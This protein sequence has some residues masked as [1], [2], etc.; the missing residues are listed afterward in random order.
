MVALTSIPQYWGL[1]LDVIEKMSDRGFARELAK[2]SRHE[3][4]WFSTI[5]PIDRTNPFNP[6]EFIGPGWSFWRGPADGNGLEGE[7]EQ[8]SRSLALTEVDLSKVLLEVHL[9]PSETHTTG[10]ERLGRLTVANR[11]RL[12]LGVFK[13]LWDNKALISASWK[14][15]TNGN[16]TYIFFDGQVLRSPSGKRYTLCLCWLGGK[17]RR[18]CRWL[19]YD[20]GAG[21]P[22]AVLAS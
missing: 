11:I 10:E 13:T 9:N 7:P 12:D 18:D 1:L 17:W 6:A 16:T 4:C 19:G 20:R 2:F 14:E 15:K 5:I 3:P 21:D 8:D 22:S